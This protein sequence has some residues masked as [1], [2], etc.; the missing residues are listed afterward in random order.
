MAG[1]PAP[2]DRHLYIVWANADPVT[3]RH[4]VLMYA[5][6]SMRNAW[7][8]GVTVVIWGA[9]QRLLCDD[10]SIR[11]AVD[12]ARGLGVEFSACLTCADIMG[13]TDPLRAMGLE[14]VRWGEKLSGLLQSG[15][16]VITV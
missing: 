16:H 4:M 15:A 8:D 6:N 1:K 13:T 9:P 11:E 12:A 5:S 2:N 14:V 10:A 3:S 7:W